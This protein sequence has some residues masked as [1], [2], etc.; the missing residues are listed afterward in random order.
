MLAAKDRRP[1]E[2]VVTLAGAPGEGARL[3][4]LAVPAWGLLGAPTLLGERPS[5]G[6][7]RPARTRVSALQDRPAGLSAARAGSGVTLAA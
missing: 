2:L 5:A 3:G 4:L 1:A 6:P 7:L